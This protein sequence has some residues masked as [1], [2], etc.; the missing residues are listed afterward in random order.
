VSSW[1]EVSSER[2]AANYRM[3]AQAAGADTA[4]LAVVKANAYGHGIESC[5]PPLALAGAPWFGVAGVDEGVRVRQC[6]HAAGLSRPP[7]HSIL[8]M[9]GFLPA[10]VPA[11]SEHALTPVLCTAQQAHWL[12]GTGMRVH[13]E[14]E[15]GMGRQGV[16][17]GPDLAALLRA[18]SAAGLVLDGLCTHFCAAEAAN[19]ELTRAQQ[20]RF[21]AA[22]EQ[23]RSWSCSHNGAPAWLHAG[24][25][26]SLDNPIAHP[27]LADLARTLGARPM[28]RCGLA[29]YGY[30]LP[31][32]GAATPAI[33]PSLKPVL[34]W[35]TRILDLREARPGDTIGYNATFTAPAPMRL[36]LLAAGYADGLR[37]ELCSTNIAPGGWVIASSANGPA[38]APIVGRISMNLT[39]A[40][41]TGI[42][43]L[44]VGDEVILL[45][46]G[47]TADDHARLA[48]TIPYEILCAIRPA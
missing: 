9:C 19:G 46:D 4:V 45:G 39:M 18:I 21:A 22:A 13:V 7:A 20:L 3:L 16:C 27:W 40:D 17:P 10:D 42:D 23:V 5:V 37:R 33:R 29:L 44:R 11:I 28:V 47:V 41:V 43:G 24:S 32:D 38:R 12:A 36:A 14:I 48:C 6:L 2:L 35:K 34:T 8:L 15:T 30:C 1:I 31:I 25:S 26:S